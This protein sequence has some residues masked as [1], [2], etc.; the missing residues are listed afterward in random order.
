MN[1]LWITKVSSK[2]SPSIRKIKGY[3]WNNIEK[4]KRIAR[5]NSWPT[6]TGANGV[7]VLSNVAQLNI[8]GLPNQIT[9]DPTMTVVVRNPTT[10]QHEEI[11]ASLLVPAINKYTPAGEIQDANT[12]PGFPLAPTVGDAREITTTSGTVWG[13][14]ITP[15]DLLVFAI[16]GWLVLRWAVPIITSVQDTISVDHTVTLWV[17]TSVARSLISNTETVD[18]AWVFAPVFYNPATSQRERATENTRTPSALG[19]DTTTVLF[20]GIVTGT[21]SA[22]DVGRFVYLDDTGGLYEVI[23]G[24]DNK[25]LFNCACSW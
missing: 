3:T 4:I 17:L 1:W 9:Y 11:L 7:Q 25:E 16:S 2:A 18:P 20:S 12:N 5:Q 24:F 6:I 22:S 21:F 13:L 23:Q 19:I 14:S 15:W 10:N 8:P